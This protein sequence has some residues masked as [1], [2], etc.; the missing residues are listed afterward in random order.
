MALEEFE[1]RDE[2]LSDRHKGYV[3]MRSM[4]DFGMGALWTAMGLFILFSKHISYDWAQKFADPSMK[5]L[6]AIFIL[7]GLFRIYRGI[8]KDYFRPR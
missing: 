8:K 6:G 1:R 2:E 7:Y 5:F 3:R 4:M